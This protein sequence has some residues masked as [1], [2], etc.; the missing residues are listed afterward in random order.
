MPGG[1]NTAVEAGGASVEVLDEK[2]DA[3][4]GEFDSAVMG[5][6]INSGEDMTD[7]LDPLS[8]GAAGTESDAPIF[9]EGDLGEAGESDENQSIAQRAAEGGSGGGSGASMTGEQ[10]GTGNG[11]QD[12]DDGGEIIPVPDDVGDGRNDDIVLRQIRDAAM[13]ERDPALRE[14]L[15]DEYRRIKGQ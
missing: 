15:W 5:E 6:G 7:I 4:L 2:L 14:K 9:E 11:G 10:S 3:S 1:D 13:K 12:G 8:N